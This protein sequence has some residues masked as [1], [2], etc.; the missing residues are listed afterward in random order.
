MPLEAR[1]DRMRGMRA[2][3]E[4]HDI[5]SWADDCLRD[6]GLL[7]EHENQVDCQ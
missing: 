4:T 7:S 3:L 5:R 2:Y 6:A 1:R